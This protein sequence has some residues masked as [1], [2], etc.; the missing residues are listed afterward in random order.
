MINLAEANMLWY[1]LA[2]SANGFAGNLREYL[3]N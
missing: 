3:N 1:N 2:R